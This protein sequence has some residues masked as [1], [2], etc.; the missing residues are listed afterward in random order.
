MLNGGAGIDTASFA[1]ET[2]AFFVDL[3][4]GTS[5]RGLAANPIEDTLVGIDNVTGGSGDDTISGTAAANNLDG[6]AGDDTLL[7]LGGIDTLIGGLGNDTLIGGAG[8]D[9]LSGG[10]GL[11]TFTYTIGDGADAVD[12]GADGDT[13]NIFGTAAG[14]TLDVIFDGT[15]IT[16]FEGGTVTG[17]EAINA[18]TL[19]GT[20][21]L[22]YAGTTAD[23]TVN[24]STGSA[25]GFASIANIENV[26]G[27]S[28]NDTLTGAGNALV[29]NLTGGAGND[30]YFVDLGDTITEAA[31]GGTNSVFTSSNTFTLAANV[32]NLTFTGAGNFAGTGNASN[33]VI[34]GGDGVDALSG[35]VG[36]DTLIGGA[37]NDVMN[38]GAGNDTFVF[39]PGFGNDIINGSVFDANPTGGQDLLDIL[40]LT[41]GD[42]A[43]RV[44][45][46]DLGPDTLVTIDGTDTI[47]LLGVNGVGANIITQQDFLLH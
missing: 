41:A 47:T 11:D 46:V 43:A 40:G 5:R 27:G 26:T 44:S 42:F 21:R 22:S 20:D 32:E 34:T 1:G 12:G 3:V 33:N 15:L 25:S 45:I 16:N 14:S 4:A 18:D 35:G 2:D 19:G 39:G 9:S 8:N 37:G 23:V 17:V 24:L 10:A 29:N 31:G 6:G 13:L 38:G 36:A 7:G 30:T 28:G